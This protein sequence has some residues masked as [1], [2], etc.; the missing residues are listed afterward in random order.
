VKAANKAQTF[1]QCMR[2]AHFCTA[3]AKLESATSAR[4]LRVKGLYSVRL[5]TSE[6]GLDRIQ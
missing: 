6:G 3:V 1:I 5:G 4:S 2:R